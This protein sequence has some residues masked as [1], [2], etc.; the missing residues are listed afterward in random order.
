MQTIYTDK[1][2]YLDILVQKN[3]GQYKIITA[4]D[5]D[6]TVYTGLTDNKKIEIIPLSPDIISITELEKDDK[7]IDR[8]FIVTTKDHKLEHYKIINNCFYKSNLKIKSIKPS[9]DNIYIIKDNKHESFLYDIDSLKM[10]SPKFDAII[11]L[12]DKFIFQKDLYL[13]NHHFTIHGKLNDKGLIDTLYN[14]YTMKIENNINNIFEYNIWYKKLLCNL[15][16]ISVK[17]NINNK[18][19]TKTES[20]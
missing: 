2:E 10:I 18:I 16:L 11:F 14:P 6:N 9:I 20:K 7:I 17:E 13:L 3:I 12:N 4:F 8:D 19:K 15:L 5:S 1:F